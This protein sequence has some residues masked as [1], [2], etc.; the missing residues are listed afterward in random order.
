MTSLF[1]PHVASR[2]VGFLR[3]YAHPRALQR[4]E[5]D[6]CDALGALSEPIQSEGGLPT[7]AITRVDDNV[8]DL[9]RRSAHLTQA[10]EAPPGAAYCGATSRG[11]LGKVSVK[12]PAIVL[13]YRERADSF[14]RTIKDLEVLDRDAHAPAIGLLSVQGS[15]ALADAVL[16]AVE[17]VRSKG[18]DHGEAA[19][20]L[21][22]WCSAHTLADGGIKHFE[23]LLGKK[24][25][26]SYEDGRVDPSHLLLAKVKMEQFLAWAFQTFPAVAQIQEVNDA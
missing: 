16:A 14:S 12:N 24:N 19:R 17:G 7:T 20:R 13:H 6:P 2:C 15:I 5:S 26:F 4:D 3:W 22:R 18:D 9:M 21:R 10:A 1:R 8:S 23:W 25:H 11:M